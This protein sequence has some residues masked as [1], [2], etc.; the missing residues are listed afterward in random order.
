MFEELQQIN[1]RPEPFKFYTAE[2]LWDDDHIS[3]QMLGFHLDGS[4]DLATRNNEFRNRTIQWILSKF[5]VGTGTSICDLGCGPGLYAVPFAEAGAEVVGVDFS[6]SSIEYAKKTA[7]KRILKIKYLLQNYLEFEP[8]KKF[9]LVTMIN[10]DFC[11]L[12]PAQRKQLLRIIGEC[13]ADD[14]AFLFD[15]FSLEYFN[16][17]EEGSTYEFFPEG[18]FWSASPHYIFNNTFKY[19]DDNLIL[20]KHTIVEESR[21]REIYNWLQCFD[22]LSIK[23]EL[24]AS[25]FAIYEYFSNIAGDAYIE[26]STEIAIIARK[27]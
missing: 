21:N 17:T 16:G 4:N 13:L 19:P 11:P 2:G 5:N 9:D 1:K 14:G 7:E 3:K 20:S 27:K 15:I 24:E 8:D 26:D 23:N 6:R 18:G 25:G 22:L 12:S 10:Y